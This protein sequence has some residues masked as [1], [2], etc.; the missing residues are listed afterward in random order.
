MS[1][2]KKCLCERR[3]FFS[4]VCRLRHGRLG[5][6]LAEH[7]VVRVCILEKREDIDLITRSRVVLAQHE[8]TI[9]ESCYHILD[10]SVR[11]LQVDL[12]FPAECSLF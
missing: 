11:T 6:R 7:R 1:A 9:L 2:K 4:L 12:L 5:V 8:N 10:C 3:L